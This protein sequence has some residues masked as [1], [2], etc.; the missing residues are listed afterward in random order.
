LLP[1]NLELEACRQE[2]KTPPVDEPP[3]ALGVST[4]NQSALDVGSS[5]YRE[6]WFPSVRMGT[7]LLGVV[8]RPGRN[9]HQPISATAMYRV[10]QNDILSTALFDVYP[11][12]LS[13]LQFGQRRGGKIEQRKPHTEAKRLYPALLAV[14][15][16]IEA[17]GRL[18]AWCDARPSQI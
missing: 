9:C 7:C 10:M 16:G 3:A 5:S 2:S 14:G 1:C 18:H 17:A 6:M 8:T 4:R 13:G 12:E 15:V 11:S